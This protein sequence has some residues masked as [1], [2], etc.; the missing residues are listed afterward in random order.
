MNISTPVKQKDDLFEVVLNTISDGVTVIDKDL[1]I[2]FQNKVI[3]QL[4]GSSMIDKHCYKAYRGRKE[5]CEDCKILDVLKDGQERRIIRDVSLPNGDILLIELNS[6]AIKDAEGNIIGAVEVARDVTEQ[7]KAEALLNKTL[8]KQNEVL[9]QLNNELSDA[10][11]YV[12][13]VLPQPIASGP[14][15]TDWRFI[16]ST[17]IG[18]D[19]FGYHWIDEDHF[20]M[21]LLDVSGHGWSAA[22]L[23]VS[24]INVLRSHA[25]PDT[26]FRE[27]HQVLFV[28]NNTFPGE[29][30]N[31]MFFTIWYGVYNKYSRKL[32]YASGGH[33]PALLLSGFSPE[34][35]QMDQLRTPNF[36]LGGNRDATYQSMVQEIQHPSRLYLFSDGVYDITK[37][38]GKIWGFNAFLEFMAQP[39]IADNAKL[40]RL[41]N[42]AQELTKKEAFEDDLTILEIVFE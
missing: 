33:P 25:L 3:T 13:T 18:G 23:S 30:N 1:R 42:Y 2:K 27:P 38:D 36:V 35:V 5:P 21:Y 6:A 29:K 19:S 4:Y 31:D 12:K 34:H 40:D 20:A 16:P 39:S 15:L 22:L 8:L 37:T 11:G 32:V 28:L 10:A 24:I 26:D 41:L 14:L 9:N 17:S 7:K